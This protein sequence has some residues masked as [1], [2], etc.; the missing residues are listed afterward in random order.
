MNITAVLQ[1]WPIEAVAA[2][3]AGILILIVP[4]ILNYVVATYLLVIGVLGL[5]HTWQAHAV[6]PQTVMAIVAGA[7][8]LIKPA[9]LSY[10][11][12]IYLILFGLLESG[13]LRLW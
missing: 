9:I 12:G 4:R 7:V 3:V 6:N 10:V 8:I 5:L 1:P 11:V 2:I 13:L